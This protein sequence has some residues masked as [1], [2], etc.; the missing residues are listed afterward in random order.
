[1]P[2]DTEQQKEEMFGLM[3]RYCQLGRMLD[4]DLD[5]DDVRALA[6]QRLVLKEMHLT[7][8]KIEKIM[9]DHKTVL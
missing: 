1:M 5:Y 3:R 7:K 4:Q 2:T 6:G 9:A 8:Q